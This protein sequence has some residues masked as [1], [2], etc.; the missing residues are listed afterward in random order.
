MRFQLTPQP[1][2]HTCLSAVC[3]H[4]QTCMV[5][6]VCNP[7]PRLPHSAPA[8]PAAAN[9]GRSRAAVGH[10]TME[11]S[12]AEAGG[13]MIR[14]V[15]H[16]CLLRRLLGCYSASQLCTPT[17]WLAAFLSRWVW[18]KLL[19]APRADALPAILVGAHRA[20]LVTRWRGLVQLIPDAC[21]QELQACSSSLATNDAMTAPHQ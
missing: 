18:Q 2:P 8:T 11:G 14:P 3:V 4:L 13:G 19:D 7:S 21:I 10:A 16:T 6:L 1:C 17:C 9:C 20:S 12:A 15:C 5:S